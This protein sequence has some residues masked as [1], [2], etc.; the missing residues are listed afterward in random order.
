MEERLGIGPAI[1]EGIADLVADLEAA[2][3]DSRSDGSQHLLWLGAELGEHTLDTGLDDAGNCASP[4]RMKDTDRP[5]HWIHQDDGD[6]VRRLYS[7]KDARLVGDQAITFQ[8]GSAFRRL[9]RIDAGVHPVDD[10]TVC[11]ARQDG[12][13]PALLRDR[14]GKATTV[15]DN[16]GIG[17]FF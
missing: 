12:S 9:Q 10:D 5:A 13:D 17:I 15:F 1:A 16:G 7:N 4:S 14:K 3:A 6:A 2:W 11:L 8:N